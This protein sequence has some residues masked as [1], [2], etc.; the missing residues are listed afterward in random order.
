MRIWI[1]SFIQV[2]RYV[3]RFQELNKDFVLLHPFQESHRSLLNPTRT[4]PG[5][6]LTPTTVYNQ[7]LS[8][9]TTVD[10]FTHFQTVLFLYPHYFKTNHCRNS[11][12]KLLSD[13]FIWGTTTSTQLSH[14]YI[15][16]HCDM[17]EW[18]LSFIIIHVPLHTFGSH[19]LPTVQ[20]GLCYDKRCLGS[21]A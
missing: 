3:P 6:F 21:P 10:E 15:R 14:I 16:H 7:T 8:S 19:L 20:G 17:C 1:D 13:R 2:P 11:P 4:P 18:V 5:A 12:M 9:P